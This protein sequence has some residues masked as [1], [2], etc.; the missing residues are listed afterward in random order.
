MRS[1][2]RSFASAAL[3]AASLTIF[4]GV[5]AAQRVSIPHIDPSSE[6]SPPRP[7]AGVRLLPN[8]KFRLTEEDEIAT[9]DAIRI[10][11]SEIADGSSYV[12]Y[13]QHGQLNGLVQ[14]TSSFKDGKGR[15]CRHILLILSAG[16]QTGRVEGIACRND[17]GRWLLEG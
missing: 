4:A 15:V 8:E 14:P 2:C 5:A 17:A 9:L 6:Q 3:L 11:L 1:F 10:A 7:E 16:R 12:W 13:R